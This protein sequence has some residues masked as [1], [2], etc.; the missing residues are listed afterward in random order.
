MEK[1]KAYVE[2]S[3]ASEKEEEEEEKEEEEE[4]EEDA[5]GNGDKSDPMG[6]GNLMKAYS[7]QYLQSLNSD[8]KFNDCVNLCKQAKV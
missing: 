5:D 8:P 7:D 6:T 1:R 2:I 3:D 4:E